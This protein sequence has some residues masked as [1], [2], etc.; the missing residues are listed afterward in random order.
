MATSASSS[1][2]LDSKLELVKRMR[3]HEIALAELD[4]LSSSRPVYQKNGNIFFRT[5]I[6]K[7]KASEQKQLDSIKAKLEKLN[8]RQSQ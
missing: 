5:T 8:S 7:A 2:A 3:S 6:Q 4:N 1:P